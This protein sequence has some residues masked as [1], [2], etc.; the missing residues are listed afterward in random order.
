MLDSN[1]HPLFRFP[2]Q[3]D[4]P[5]YAVRVLGFAGL[6]L[7]SGV[8]R[9]MGVG[10]LGAKEA[11]TLKSKTGK[12][13]N[14]KLGVAFAVLLCAAVAFSFAG[15]R[16]AIAA[17]GEGDNSWQIVSGKYDSAHQTSQG[18]AD[19]DLGKYS[20]VASDD[21]EDGSQVRVTKTVE[22]TGVEDEFVVH[23]SVDTSATSK[24]VTDY[25]TFFRN[26]P[27]KGTTSN[28]YHDYTAGTVT[29]DEMGAF[30]VDVS[31]T[32]SYGNKGVFDIYDPE[33]RRIAKDVTLYWSQA[34]NVTILLNIG[35]MLGLDYNEY[36]L[37]GIEIS[38]NAHNDL[39]LSKEAYDLINKA[40]QGETKWGDPTR[41]TSV[42]DVM[43][44]G[45][46]YLGAASADGGSAGYNDDSRSL[47]WSPSYKGVYETVEEE[48]VID[49]ERN[50]E[51][52]VM[53][54]TV[55][56]RKW[57]Y[58]VAS[59]TYKVRLNTQA[60]GFDSSYDPGSVSNPY[61]TNNDATLEYSYSVDGGE[62]YKDGSVDFPKPTVKGILY[63]L[64]AL[65]TN[66]VQT[67]LAG[68]TF[69]LTRSWTDSFGAEHIDLISDG[70]ISDASGYVKYGS[71]PWGTYTLEETAPPSGHTMRGDGPVTFVLSY[72]SN[73]A[74]LAV[75]TLSDAGEHHAMLSGST[76]T[77]V[78]DRVKTDVTLLK[79][80]SDTSNPLAGARFALY[81]DDGDGAFDE[82][83]DC[84]DA[85]KVVEGETASDGTLVFGQLT[86]GTYYLK[87][88][89]TPAGYELNG[90]VYRIDVYDVEGAAGGPDG[91]MI[92]VG[93]AD[94][95]DMQPPSTA[96]R[97]TVADR[98]I[99]DL[100]V[101]AGPGTAA[102]TACGAALL[103]VG[104]IALALCAIG[105]RRGRHSA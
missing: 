13:L 47:T 67:P 105:K 65:K 60:D 82:K 104:S 46:E 49:I 10:I 77:V 90:K 28:G 71:L 48:P 2:R 24:Q 15:Q 9:G 30:K 43:G 41:L 11:V 84:A 14:G 56:Q 17:D 20:F 69:K 52:A 6:I 22:P 70:L 8:L 92:R 50:A 25:E 86:V 102:L 101:T 63:D 19:S 5:N 12:L 61:L 100:P 4:F 91:N 80:D 72:T 88:T 21:G 57:C 31:G 59:L 85:R 55:T 18:I 81:A 35:E 103:A 78:N 16:D 79:V 94:G 66:E 64:Q 99:P 1:F 23:L 29:K 38:K 39:H 93:D 98:P 45:V 32:A 26:A 62:S 87:E 37:M 51:G 44:G 3:G 27:Y 54:V 75:S 53:K 95:S 36:I 33:G 96:N 73:R 40:I 7:L 68:A 97:V 76:P 34:N 58:G 42:T 74:N 83:T 89:Y